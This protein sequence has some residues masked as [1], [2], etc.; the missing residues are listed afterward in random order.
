M[1]SRNYS[2]VAEREKTVQNFSPLKMKLSNLTSSFDQENIVVAEKKPQPIT[3]DR[4]KQRIME[5]IE[6]EKPKIVSH[7]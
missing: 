4:I 1:K 7:K 2:S 5:K 3:N 6:E